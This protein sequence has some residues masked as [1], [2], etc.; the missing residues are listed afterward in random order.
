M[1]NT[2]KITT[3]IVFLCTISLYIEIPRNTC[4]VGNF[5]LFVEMLQK[6]RKEKGNEYLYKEK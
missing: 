6:Q 5:F 1:N 4:K 3:I 2:E